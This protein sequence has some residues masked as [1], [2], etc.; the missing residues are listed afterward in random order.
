MTA[1]D[2]PEPERCPV[3]DPP[4]GID[5]SAFG[6]RL[7]P[8]RTKM[9]RSYELKFGYD[10]FNPGFG[11]TRFAP[12]DVPPDITIPTLY[13]A[14]DEVAAL[15]ETVMH[16]VHQDVDDRVI[17]GAVA[18]NWGLVSVRLPR[19]LALVDLRVDAL[20][21]IGLTRDQ[22]LTTTAQHYACTREWAAWLHDEVVP[23]VD[24]DGIVWHS[25]QAEVRGIDRPREVCVLFGD[26]APSGPG[27]YALTGA[28]V[29]N[30]TEG[31]GLLLLE[32]L[33]EQL[34]ARIEPA[35]D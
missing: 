32:R 2:C 4:S 35:D 23:G 7:L 27:A 14:E 19:A 26:R 10:S 24:P 13:A 8:V 6:L 29:G 16:D 21:R 22:I 3:P 5:A 28:G 15:L 34:D 11:D 9:W 33:A 25:R 31:R 30:L 18:R 17:Y 1:P 20:A 12:L